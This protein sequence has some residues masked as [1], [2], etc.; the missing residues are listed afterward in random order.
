VPLRGSP[1]N[2]DP[3]WPTGDRRRLRVAHRVDALLDA[4]AEPKEVRSA[5]L[6]ISRRWSW[7]SVFPPMPKAG[8]DASSEVAR[9]VSVWNVSPGCAPSLGETLIQV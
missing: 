1:S 3:P 4:A 9:G 5:K 7:L 2:H 8:F 6:R